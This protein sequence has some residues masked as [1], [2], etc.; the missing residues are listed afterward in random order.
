L[1]KIGIFDSGYG[2]LTIFRNIEGLLPSHDYIYLGDNARTPYGNRSF[3]TI[4]RFTVEGVRYL[5]GQDCRLIIIACNTASAKALR[6]VQQ[7][8]LPTDYPDRRVLGVIRPS[9]EELSRF[10]K[11]RA[12]AL[13]GTEGTVNSLSFVLELQKLAPE[14]D[15]YQQACPM[16]VPLVEAGELQGPGVEYYVR[17]YWRRTILHSGK[18]DVL[19]LACTHYPLIL[20]VIRKIVPPE[21]RILVQGEI[22]APS[23]ADYLRRHPE[24]ETA[25]SREGTRRFLT[26]DQSE[27]F[28]R[29]AEAFLGYAV[30]SEKVEISGCV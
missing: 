15:L 8:I 28:D 26:T 30:C 14:I 17:E 18:V 16:L 21:V 1:V 9:A 20:P 4:Y 2:G 23:L 29:L 10:T 5:F 24:I 12:V 11:T 13:W 22:V 7:R 25:M 19:L 6:N 27:L 3:D